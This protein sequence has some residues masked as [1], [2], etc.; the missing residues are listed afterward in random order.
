MDMSPP[1]PDLELNG[2]LSELVSSIHA[3]LG[4]N[5]LAAYLHGSFAVGDWDIHSD[6]D[7]LV[8]IKH[9]LL[10]AELADLQTMHARIYNLK[11]QWAQHLDGSYVPQAV[12]KCYNGTAQPLLYLDNGSDHLVRSNHDNTQVV[13]WVVRERGITLAGPHPHML[14][15][16]VSTEALRQEVSATMQE[17]GQELIANPDKM[18]N[19][20][21]QPFV[22]L[23]YC[24]M[25]HTLQT[26]RVESKRAGA[27]WAQSELDPGWA[28]LIQR[29]WAERP[30]PSVKIGLKA[31]PD[32]F[33]RTF[34]FIAYALNSRSRYDHGGS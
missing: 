14:I 13:R 1:T 2:V 29:A 26:G 12:L 22:V 28:G 3:S 33:K 31:D 7:F 32:D 9:E 19:R 17:W 6:V 16:P 5:F 4:D 11:S 18:D 25:L 15:D 30:D 21:Y 24:R 8:A 10:D 34:D 27:Q 20:W 23:S